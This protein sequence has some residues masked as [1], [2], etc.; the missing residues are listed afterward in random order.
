MKL[1]GKRVSVYY[2]LHKH[3]WSVVYKGLV[4]SHQNEIHLKD[5][6]F[7]VGKRGRERVLKFKRKN[8]HARVYGTVVESAQ[9]DIQV[10]YNPY[11]AGYF[12]QSNNKN[13]I[14][15]AASVR[16]INKKVFASL[17]SCTA[18]GFLA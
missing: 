3:C 8:V 5:V 11:V 13:P 7:R 18:D 9:G 17:E 2:N 4:V 15:R 10:S 6:Q 1:E 14:Y 12:F 16:M